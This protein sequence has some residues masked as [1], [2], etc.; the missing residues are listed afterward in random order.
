MTVF[1]PGRLAARRV[2]A[3]LVLALATTM[4]LGAHAETDAKV[5]ALK[6]TL[7]ER[8]GSKAE[9]SEIRKSP[10]AGL[11]EVDVNKQVYYADPT[12]QY[13]MLGEIRDTTTG[14]NLTQ[15][16]TDQINRIDFASLPLQDAVKVVHG[17][18]AR[19]IAVFSDPH[20]PYC[21]KL[22]E[23]LQKVDNV[24][25]Y[26][27]LFPI[28]SPDSVAKSK[29]IW[30]AKDRGAAWENW[31]LRKQVPGNDGSC[32]VAVLQRNLAMGQSMNVTG[33]PTVFLVDGNRLPG[34]V[35]SDNLE[36]ALKAAQASNKKS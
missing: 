29:A 10:I 27:F 15:E 33:T 23:T 11:Y 28:L 32:N 25:V 8:L 7:Q 13:L 2:G 19:K 30:C 35:D 17:N 26:T 24:T 36:K 18:G 5:E 31:M 1:N 34:A 21:H 9:I 12:G 20:C 14:A 22:E 6:K 4:S 16:R 3:A